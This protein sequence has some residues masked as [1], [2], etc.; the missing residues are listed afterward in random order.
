MPHGL[1]ILPAWKEGR[2]TAH[3]QFSGSLE[4]KMDETGQQAA[5]EE[6]P[7]AAFLAR[8]QDELADIAED[9]LGFMPGASEVSLSQRK[10]QRR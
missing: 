3:A 4:K 5:F 1:T 2:S 6:D 9:P 10:G 7:A 8:E